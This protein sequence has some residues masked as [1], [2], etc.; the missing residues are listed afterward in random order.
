MEGQIETLANQLDTEIG[1]ITI[2]T[3]AWILAQYWPGISVWIIV[4][5]ATALALAGNMF[6]GQ[7]RSTPTSTDGQILAA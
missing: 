4:A 1:E 7:S 3:P 2:A 6:N 5:A